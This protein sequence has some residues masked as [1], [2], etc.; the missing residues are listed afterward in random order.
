MKKQ[1][2]LALVLQETT[3]DYILEC[4]KNGAS[5]EEAFAEAKTEKAQKI[6]LDRAIK[7]TG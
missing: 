1:Q 3:F 6:I 7:I 4:I 2:E 5:K